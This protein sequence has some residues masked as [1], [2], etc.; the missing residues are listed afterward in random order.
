M[1]EDVEHTHIPFIVRHTTALVGHARR[2]LWHV[3][4]RTMYHF[5]TAT[6]RVRMLCNS[7]C[8]ALGV[9]ERE[10]L[11]ALS[12]GFVGCSGSSARAYSI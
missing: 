7:F 12:G 9:G 5:A 11:S 3:R 6:F 10:P 2:Q 1:G 4:T 8:R